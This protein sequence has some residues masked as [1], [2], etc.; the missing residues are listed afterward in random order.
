M[1]DSVLFKD[2]QLQ[3]EK[4]LQEHEI[5]MAII[6]SVYG[7][8]LLWEPQFEDAQLVCGN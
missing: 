7:S 1:P 5:K 8:K 6:E 4:E 3:G 2:Q